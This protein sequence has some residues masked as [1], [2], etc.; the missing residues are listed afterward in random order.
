N[1]WVDERRDI[2][3]STLAAVEYL[4]DLYTIF[5]SWELAA[6]AYNA[7]EAKIARAVRRYGSK[8]FWVIS[9]QRFLSPETRDYVPKIIAAAIISKNRGLFGFQEQQVKPGADEAVAGDG[10]LVKVI[11]TDKPLE[12]KEAIEQRAA[13]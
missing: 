12:D 2:R 1:W 3:K 7:G 10:E 4:R 11:K 9:R 8:D 5:Q 13:D 6:A